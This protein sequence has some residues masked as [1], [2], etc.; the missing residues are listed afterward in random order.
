MLSADTL[1]LTLQPQRIKDALKFYPGQ[2]AA[3]GFRQGW[4]PTPM[5][6]FSIVSSPNKPDEL[7]FA[8]RVHGSFTQMAKELEV[9]AE[10]FLQGPFGNF[11]LDP[12]YDH[13]A[14]LLAG[15]IGITPFM[16]MLRYAAETN[17]DLPITLLYSCKSASDIPF[18]EELQKLEKHN[19][20]F[21][22][23]YFIT[24]GSAE[25]V[26][27]D[28]AINGR[29]N[30]SRLNRI[31]AGR[32]NAFTYFICG[33]K[34]FI[35]SLETILLDNGTAPEHI[36]TEAFTPASK[37]SSLNIMPQLSVSK[38]TY[39]LT[40]LALVVGA[41]TVMTLDLANFAPKVAKAQTA[42][43]SATTTTSLPN[44]SSTTSTPTTSTP[45]TNDST[46]TM[47]TTETPTV[48]PT[49]P[50]TTLQPTQTTQTYQVP[51]T[52]VS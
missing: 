4:R 38:L 49:T 48:S 51:M 11:V 19:P 25:H 18:F 40:S 7:Q 50:D 8:M 16:S 41:G 35:S 45:I 26:E 36:I 23:R 24:D 3:I 10:V 42:T 39:A 28:H 52:S 14:V 9:G 15:G 37:Q 47:P 12:K 34:S 13:S 27:T 20:H 30:E 46:S 44:T 2:Y 33:P 29:I 32:H 22:V 17:L 6:C 1:L 31:A 21:Q 5:R 43:T